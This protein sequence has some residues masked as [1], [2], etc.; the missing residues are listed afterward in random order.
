MSELFNSLTRWQQ[1]ARQLL[2]INAC[3][4]EGTSDFVI[5]A[6]R[7]TSDNELHIDVLHDGSMSNDEF[8]HIFDAADGYEV[9]EVRD[10]NGPDYAWACTG[11]D[12]MTNW[13]IVV[14]T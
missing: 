7:M 12:E 6:A 9:V 1:V 2:T 4:P 5:V 8:I 13:T 10:V 11:S 3:G 14:M